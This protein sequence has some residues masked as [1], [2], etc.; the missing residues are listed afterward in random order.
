MLYDNR[1]AAAFLEGRPVT[2]EKHFYL[3]QE[4]K[5]ADPKRRDIV[6]ELDSQLESIVEEFPTFNKEL[7]EAVFPNYR[8]QLKTVCIMAVV[9]TKENR[10]VKSEEGLCILIDLIHIADYTRIVSQMTYILQN[11]LTFELSK[12]LIQKQF[13]V[14]SRKTIWHS[15]T[16]L[17]IIWH[18]MLP[19]AAISFIHRNMKRIRSVPSVFFHRR[20]RWKQKPYSIRSWSVP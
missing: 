10:I 3:L 9:G 18:G 11:Y 2:E 5:E 15:Q 12:Y 4:Y 17:R 13:P 14:R 20:C 16:V 1:I 6:Q 7:F 19:A 8:E